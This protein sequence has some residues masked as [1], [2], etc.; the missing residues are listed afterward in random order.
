M[1]LEPPSLGTAFIAEEVTVPVVVLSAP[2]TTCFAPPGKLLRPM[3]SGEAARLGDVL[4]RED[5]SPITRRVSRMRTSGQTR[6][7]YMFSKPG[8]YFLKNLKAI[9]SCA[10]QSTS[11]LVRSLTSQQSTLSTWEECWKWAWIT[12]PSRGMMKN[13]TPDLLCHSPV[14]TP[15]LC[16][17]TSP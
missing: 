2:G 9:S 4:G 8:T 12:P 1:S 6:V 16:R 5:V 15:F 10:R 13:P 14:S 7:R 11:H 3:V 17:E